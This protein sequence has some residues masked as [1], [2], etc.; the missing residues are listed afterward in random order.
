MY[1]IFSYDEFKTEGFLLSKLPS[2]VYKIKKHNEYKPIKKQMKQDY[3]EYKKI[4]KNASSK[5][6]TTSTN[7]NGI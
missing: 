4:Y 5:Q 6:S 3:T 2:V 1:N 7:D